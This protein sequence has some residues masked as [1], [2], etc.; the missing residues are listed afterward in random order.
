MLKILSNK[1]LLNPGP[2]NTR[3]ETKIA[4]TNGSDVC[5]RTKAFYEILNETKTMLLQRFTKDMNIS[6]DNDTWYVALI[7]GSGTT[8]METMISSL[9]N[10]AKQSKVIK[11]GKYGDRISDMLNIYGII[12]QTM[13][14]NSVEDLQGY[15][16]KM[17]LFFVENETTNGEKYSLENISSL[18]PHA[19][20]FI[21]ATSAFGA[22]DY[23]QHLDNIQAISFCSNKCLQSTPGL[24]I[25]I[26]RKSLPVFQR[27][28]YCYLNRYT[29]TIPPFTLPVQA[30]YALHQTLKIAPD[31]TELFDKR[32]D[33]L[34]TSFN[35][36]GIRCMNK[37]P[38]NSII[39]FIHPKM[40]YNQLNAFLIERNIVIYEG[41][42][43]YKNS[44]RIATMSVLFDDKFNGIIEIF[45]ESTK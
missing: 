32:K 11:A 23:L 2:T 3:E 18:F 6:F 26:W 25:V 19:N 30:V 34:I 43:G 10:E 37:K 40:D 12:H 39:G 17:D 21:D 42:T 8:A 20:L 13:T 38:C 16:R 29:K 35:Q 4:Q 36:I 5:H 45:K 22:G 44:F 27:T 1:I 31:N 15:N 7:G 33:K 41:I 9:G 24:G 14:A 28:Y